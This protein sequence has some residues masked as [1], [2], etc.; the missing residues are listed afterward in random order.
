MG[1]FIV[2]V[3]TQQAMNQY[4]TCRYIPLGS[5]KTHPSSQQVYSLMGWT[6]MISTLATHFYGHSGMNSNHA[7][8]ISKCQDSFKQLHLMSNAMCAQ[9]KIVNKKNFQK[10]YI[11]LQPQ[12]YLSLLYWHALTRCQHS[13]S[14]PDT[15]YIQ[16]VP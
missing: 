2:P 16:H 1:K 12:A 4:A 7:L 3:C 9:K 6:K 5:N 13:S 8:N 15:R 10:I 14:L 11:Q